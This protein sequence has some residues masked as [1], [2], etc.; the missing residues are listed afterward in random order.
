MVEMLK[1]EECQRNFHFIST[2]CFNI[3]LNNFKCIYYIY[4]NVK[5]YFFISQVIFNLQ[6]ASF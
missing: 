1:V 6:N 5:T 4:A 2:V 3:K